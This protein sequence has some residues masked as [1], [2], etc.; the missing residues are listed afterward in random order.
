MSGGSRVARVPRVSTTRPLDVLTVNYGGPEKL[1]RCLAGVR[2]HLPDAQIRV[3]DNRSSRTDEVRRFAE[4]Y[5]DIDWVFS[6]EGIGFSAA[7]NRLVARSDHDT[8]MINSD[9]LLTG[10]L[11]RTREALHSGERIAGVTPTVIDPTGHTERWDIAHRRQ[12]I[13]RLWLNFAGYAPRLRRF[14]MLSDLY[15]EPPHEVDGYINPCAMVISRDAWNSV[16]PLDESYFVY[17]EDADW[18]YRASKQGWRILMVDEPHAVHVSS[19]ASGGPKSTHMG[20][21]LAANTAALAGIHRGR[22]RGI[23]LITGMAVLRRVQRSKRRARAAAAAQRAA[24][25]QGRVGIVIV[26]P[27]RND[28]K[29]RTELANEF[30]RRGHPVVVVCLDDELG[31]LQRQLDTTVRM[32]LRPSWLPEVDSATEPAVMI[33]GDT[34]EERR[35]AAGWTR[36]GRGR[37]R[38]LLA[39]PELGGPDPQARSTAARKALDRR[40]AWAVDSSLAGS[41]VA[42]VADAYLNAVDGQVR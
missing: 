22:G 16:G 23:V 17:G 19:Q 36:L 38:W 13:L 40:R 7:M 31:V 30:V 37:R 39:G 4:Q 25:A 41:D 14:P 26:A 15:P 24:E 6:E 32:M 8:L 35:F 29:A 33:T 28:G 1:E 34:P 3:W 5:P 10:P 11:T 12:T 2:E 9:A 27:D 20:D 21:L 42:A 18:H